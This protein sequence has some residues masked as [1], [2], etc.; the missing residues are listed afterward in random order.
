M[1][2]F[3]TYT[4]LEGQRWDQ[5]AFAEYGDPFAYERLLTANPAYRNVTTLPGGVALRVPVVDGLTPTILP[6]QLPPWKR[7]ANA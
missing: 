5:I 6:E 1:A 3:R 2:S 7:P 4:P